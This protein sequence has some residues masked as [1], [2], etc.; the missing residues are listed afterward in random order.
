MAKRKS[1]FDDKPVEIQELTY[2]IKQD[3]KSLNEKIAQLQ[4]VS[5]LSLLVQCC[6]GKIALGL[7]GGGGGDVCLLVGCLESQQHVSVSQGW[8]CTDKFTCCHTDIEVAD[9]T[10]YLTQSQYTDT[11]PT[12]HSTD[13]IMPGTWQGSHWSAS[14][15]DTVMTQP[16]KISLQA[17][18]EPQIFCSRGRRL[19]H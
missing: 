14:F 12:S 11:R 2:I 13:P 7:F 18:F 3:I 4:A 6:H 19:N 5:I 9:Q 15:Y 17:G 16:R 1:L 10:F 8:I